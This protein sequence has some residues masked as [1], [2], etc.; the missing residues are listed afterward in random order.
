MI[1]Q[2][3]NAFKWSS[4]LSLDQ[5]YLAIWAKKGLSYSQVAQ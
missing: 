4:F 5:P 2:Q 3:N 1:E